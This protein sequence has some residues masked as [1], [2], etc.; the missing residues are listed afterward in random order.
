MSSY[1]AVAAP[2]AQAPAGSA[3]PSPLARVIAAVRDR[4]DTPRLMQA[5]MVAIWLAVLV[6]VL[7]GNAVVGDARRTV[8][9]IGKDAAPSIVASQ[10]MK[11]SMADM[12]A[13]AANDSMVEANGLPA[14]RDAYEKDRLS[15]M[16]GLVAAARNITYPEEP[17][18]IQELENDMSLYAAYVAQARVYNQL[19]SL[20]AAA[21]ALKTASDLMHQKI[22]P[23]A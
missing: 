16:S 4:A 15:V 18:L 3:Q 1:P 9:T 7:V 14:A 11:A 23:A 12:D 22:V 10:S 13:N 17:P 19:G 5:A 2:P 21:G 6:L 20:P 8:Q